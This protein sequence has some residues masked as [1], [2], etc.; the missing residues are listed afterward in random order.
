[1]TLDEWFWGRGPVYLMTCR[2]YPGRRDRARR[3]MDRIGVR[4]VESFDGCTEGDVKR[5]CIRGK[6]L[7]IARH[8][9]SDEADRGMWLVEDDLAFLADLDRARDHLC[10]PEGPPADA[11]VTLCPSKYNMAFVPDKCRVVDFGGFGWAV[12]SRRRVLVDT[13]KFIPAPL[14]RPA[15]EA[16]AGAP[17]HMS[18][19]TA[20]GGAVER[21]GAEIWCSFP[22]LAI[23][24]RMHGRERGK[25]TDGWCTAPLRNRLGVQFHLPRSAYGY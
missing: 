19:D 13:M 7:A 18:G 11:V 25:C 23:Q 22:R 16:L 8:L 2:R 10:R 24:S 20:V 15:L 4:Y 9:A 1:M 3:E 5:G 21:S 14:V 12:T 6:A 17:P